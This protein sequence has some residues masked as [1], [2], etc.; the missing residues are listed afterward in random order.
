MCIRDRKY[1]GPITCVP[2]GQVPWSVTM[3][4]SEGKALKPGEARVAT[5]SFTNDFSLLDIRELIVRM[6][7]R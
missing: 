7:G 6:T 1:T 2:G 4:S 3:A 5:A